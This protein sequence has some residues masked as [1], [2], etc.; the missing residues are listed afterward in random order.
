[1]RSA[2]F[3]TVGLQGASDGAHRRDLDFM[4]LFY[5]IRYVCRIY[6]VSETLPLFPWVLIFVH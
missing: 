2:R 5:R 6:Y 1:M 3:K 4:S